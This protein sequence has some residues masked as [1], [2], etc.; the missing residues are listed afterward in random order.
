[1]LY[2]S[3]IQM[4]KPIISNLIDISYFGYAYLNPYYKHHRHESSSICSSFLSTS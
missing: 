3:A 2:D 4:Y 1:M